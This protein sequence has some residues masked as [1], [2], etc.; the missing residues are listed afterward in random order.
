VIAVSDPFWYILSDADRIKALRRVHTALKPGGIVILECPNFLWI[1]KHYRPP[2]P[3]TASLAGQ[4]V[5]RSP[6]HAIDF[7]E[8]IWTHRDRFTITNANGI[9]TVCDEHRFAMLTLPEV[10]AALHA[11]GFADCKRS[12]VTR[13]ARANE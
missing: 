11:T 2:R 12:R 6:T 3:S 8:A 7:H 5:H 10:T 9:A 1:L 4:E 13:A